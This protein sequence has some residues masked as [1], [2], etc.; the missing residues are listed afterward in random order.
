MMVDA[1]LNGE[2][3]SNSVVKACYNIHVYIVYLIILI[4]L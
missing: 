2:A 3:I 1:Q 4:T